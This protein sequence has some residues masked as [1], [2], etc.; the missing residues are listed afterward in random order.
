VKALMAVA[1]GALVALSFGC[2]RDESAEKAAGK[3]SRGVSAEKGS[4]LPANFP[5]DVPMP[6]AGTLQLAMSQGGKTLVQVYTPDSV[7][8]AGKFYRAALV[9]GG[10]QIEHTDSTADLFVISATKGKLHCGV[11]VSK[12]GKRTLVRMTVTDGKS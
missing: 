1:L 3:A 9:S 10:W 7:G 2:G 12:E 5:P 4:D 8:D 11:T 6:R